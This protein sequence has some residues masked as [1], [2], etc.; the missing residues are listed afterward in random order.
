MSELPLSKSQAIKA[1]AFIKTNF[2][3]KIVAATAG[4]PFD[5]NTICGIACQETAYKWLLWLDKYP[6]DII[7]ARC[8]FDAT[9]DMKGTRNAFPKNSAAFKE[10]YGQEFLDML[11]EEGNKQ[12]AMPQADAPNGYKSAKYLYNGYGLFQ[13]DLQSVVDDEAFFKEKKWYN[14][15]DC[16]RWVMKELNSKY[17]IKKDVW[18]AIKAYNGSGQVATDYAN[19]VTKFTEIARTI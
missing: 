10:K 1:S 13:L 9:G 2:S 3:D 5:I 7:L 8:V 4:T 15:D 12:R 14:L 18:V 17:A 11:V 16:L 6:I 19:N